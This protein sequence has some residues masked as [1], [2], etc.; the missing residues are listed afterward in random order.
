[1]RRLL[2]GLLLFLGFS[3]LLVWPW[4]WF[5]PPTS[6]FMLRMQL[7]GQTYEYDWVDWSSISPHLPVAIVAAEDQKFP[8]HRGFD[9]DQIAYAIEEHK[10][11]KRFRGA[12]TIS[13]QV[14][15]NLYLWP[16]PSY[17]RK[18]LE[19]YLTVWIEIL[20][21]KKRILE[22]YMNIAQF[23][24]QIFGVE[25]ASR[26]YFN[27]TAVGLTKRQAARLAVILPNPYK[28]KVW[29]VSTYVR[30]RTATIEKQMRLLGGNSYLAN[31]R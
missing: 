21:P 5:N 19:A 16:G 6:A 18:A 27:R 3:L 9:F 7:K 15:K 28:L 13:Q 12:S 1:M 31:L 2:V 20:W 29:P 30:Q 17:L 11:K 22:I 26:K 10:A 24:P 8:Y 4:R 14:A 23:G 25:K